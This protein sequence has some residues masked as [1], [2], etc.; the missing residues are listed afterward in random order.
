MGASVGIGNRFLQASVGEMMVSRL[1]LLALGLALAGE[2]ATAAPVFAVPQ[3]P[4]LPAAG[5]AA[6]LTF[7]NAPLVGS[8]LKQ[9]PKL[10]LSVNGGPPVRGVMDTGSTGVVIAARR[11]PN[12]HTLPVIRPGTLTYSSSGRIMKGVWVKAPITVTGAEGKSITTRPMAVLAVTSIGCTPTARRCQPNPRP[13]HT[14]MIGIGFA[15][16]TGDGGDLGERNP[17]LNLEGMGS[18]EAPG[19]MRRGYLVTRRTVEVGLSAPSA[20]GMTYIKLDKAAQGPGWSALPVCISIGGRQPPSCG[21]ALLDTGVTVMYLDLSSAQL[22]GQTTGTGTGRSLMPGKTVALALG[23]GTP[24]YSFTVGD[25]ADPVAPDRVILVDRKDH[26]FV[27]TS[28]R[29]LNGF[30]YLYDA[31]G[32][33]VGFRPVPAR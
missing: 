6:T 31:D 33:F 14:A 3:G 13:L 12:F 19:T 26:I 23:T 9:T 7:L 20:E 11:I 24:S 30:D 15:R 32:G 10:G 18:T 29:L 16:G 5:S 27:N 25:T 8:A 21:T 2:I 28:A 1:R 22:K 4:D 17:F